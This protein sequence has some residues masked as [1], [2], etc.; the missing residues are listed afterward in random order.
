ML[1]LPGARL[2]PSFHGSMARCSAALLRSTTRA[3]Y[4]APCG[5]PPAPLPL[6]AVCPPSSSP[7]CVQYASFVRLFVPFVRSCYSRREH[8]GVSETSM[9]DS[10]SF[11]VSL[12]LSVS[13]R[14]S[15]P[16]PTAPGHPRAPLFSAARPFHRS[17][18]AR[19]ST[20]N[21]YFRS[22]AF[23]LSIAGLPL[24]RKVNTRFPSFFS[25]TV[26]RDVVPQLSVI[27]W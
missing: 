7:L 12:R 21:R 8:P 15:V 13:F 6:I 27:N 19:V 18:P 16:A 25:R 20:V 26:Q 5:L 2:T 4:S 3:F 14:S 23:R 9:R 1:F 24:P 22:D 17:D 10:S 11:L